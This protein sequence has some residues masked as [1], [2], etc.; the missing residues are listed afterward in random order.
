MFV[1][2]T[3]EANELVRAR[4]RLTGESMTTAVTVALR[5][6]LPRKR[7]RREAATDLPARLAALAGRLRSACDTR[8]VNRAEWDAA[9]G[10]EA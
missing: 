3:V 8:Q 10:N 6:R 9:S 4:A 5:D 7:A 1:T 2:K